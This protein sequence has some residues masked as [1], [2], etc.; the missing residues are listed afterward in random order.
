[1]EMQVDVQQPVGLQPK[2]LM[3]EKGV[4][5]IWIATW[6]VDLRTQG[7]SLVDDG[8]TDTT[9]LVSDSYRY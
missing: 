4:L 2:V 6:K 5:D 9:L 1:M 7:D 8:E 3:Q